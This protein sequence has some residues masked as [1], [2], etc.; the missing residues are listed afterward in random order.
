ELSACTRNRLICS[1]RQFQDESDGTHSRRPPL[2][3]A[4]LYAPSPFEP[5]L[6]RPKQAIEES[7][8]QHRSEAECSG[9]FKTVRE[10]KLVGGRGVRFCCVNTAQN[11]TGH[12]GTKA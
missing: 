2:R 1:S 8:N 5:T 11:F 3:Y 7:E 9:R 6:S 12:D 10:Q 4:G